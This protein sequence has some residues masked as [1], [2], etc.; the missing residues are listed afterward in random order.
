MKTLVKL[1][2]DKI[3]ETGVAV[4]RRLFIVR[5]KRHTFFDII[6]K[7]AEINAA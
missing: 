6:F 4:M 7:K 5:R 1:K 3:I 2:D